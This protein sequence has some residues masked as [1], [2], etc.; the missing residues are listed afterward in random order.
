MK[1]MF[2]CRRKP[3]GR[4]IFAVLLFLTAFQF[5]FSG[6][7]YAQSL[8]VT[9]TIKDDVGNVQE[10][11]VVKVKGSDKAVTTDNKGRYTITVPGPETVLVFSFVGYKSVEETVGQ[12]KQIDITMELTGGKL[13]DVVVVGY[14]TQKKKDLTG[15]I[16]TVGSAELNKRVATDPTQ[17]L[18]GKLPGLSLTQSSGEAGNENFV[19]RIRGLGTNSS[20]GSSPL[21]IVDGLPGSL[22]NLDPQNIESITLLKDAASAAIYGT[23]AANGVI[24]VTTKQGSNGKFQLSYDLN[25]GITRPTALPK[26]LVYNSATYMEMW[27][28]AAINSNYSNRYTQAQIDAYKNPSDPNL[29]PNVNWL[30]IVMRN[31]TTQTHHIGMT[32]GR[33]GTTYNVGLGY[34]DQPDIMIGFSYKKYNLQF[35][36]NSKINDWAT[37]GGSM[38]FNYGKRLYASRGSQDQFLSAMS[39]E[40][41]TGPKLPD[42]SGRY[43]NSV[44]PNVQ[45]PN[46]NPVA[47]AENALVNNMDYYF[48]NNIYINI[49]LLKGLE[50]R[51]SGGFNYDFQKTKDFKP[52]INQYNWFAGPNDAPE[53]TLDVNGQGMTVTDN[54]YIYPVGYTQLTYS[55][56][57][58]NHNFKALAGTQAEYNKTEVLAGSRNTPFST[59]QLDELS[60][61]PSG[62]QLAT[63]TTSEWSLRSYY[64]RLNYDYDGKYLF[65]ANA[66]YDASSRFPPENKWALFPSF[67]AGWVMTREKFLEHIPWL[68]TLKLRGSWGRLGNQNISN[69]PYQLVY[70]NL[71]AYNNN[72]QY[73]YSYSGN[74]LNAGAALNALTDRNI[75]WE[76]TRVVDVGMDVTVFRSLNVTFDWYNKFTYDILATPAIP[77]YVGLSAPTINN[78]QMRNTGF[79]ASVQYTGK[80]AD[81]NYS[82]GGTFQANKNTLVKYGAQ[83]INTGNN[84]INIEGQPYGSFY[85]LKYAGIF[86][87]ADEINKSP[88]QQFNPQPGFLKFEDVIDDG[89]IDSKDRVI[90]PGV[91]PKFDYSFNASASWKN[92]DMTIFL[93]GSYGQKIYANGWGVQPFNQGSPPTYDWLNAWSP[94]NPSTTMPLIY[95]TGQGDASSNIGTAST[96]YL[97][98]GSFLRIK[99][100]Q[101]GYTLPKSIANHIAM[102]SLRVF[103]SGDNLATFTKFKG[104]DPERVP[105]SSNN[106]YVV[107]PQNQV[108]SFGV[109]AVF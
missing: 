47:I 6:S 66:R 18:Q 23:R 15:A 94:S 33:N 32:G 16:A 97:K 27:N 39:Q 82:V 54:N 67:S 49:R 108:F 35:N 7:A 48:Q 36:L 30:D 1:K 83:Q 42:G 55:K 17:L 100:L 50:W 107:H 51:T 95:I 12:R 105:S 72:I 56:E 59:N 71:N 80:V 11:T 34:V 76:N 70:S 10:G 25:V 65:E 44:Y 92:F 19:L 53:R 21:I 63:G 86:Q 81:V 90:V 109:K 13:D 103:A 61:G 79:E 26:N 40:P 20:A 45:G 2:D 43:V 14:G 84:T 87:S 58:G 29:Y 74:S 75:H 5:T 69:Y 46:K 3:S 24:L 57:I 99:N 41:M 60:A 91:F 89:V 102:S 4:F 38:T 77:A 64:G 8:V 62:S 78:G 101:V 68:N 28:Q 73:A 98:D 93:Y 37:I 85:M 22:T 106:R 52:V 9:G 96:F 31:V 104:L 88:K